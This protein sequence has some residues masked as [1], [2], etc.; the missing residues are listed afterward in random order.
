MGRMRTL[1]LGSLRILTI[2]ILA[3]SGS[4]FVSASAEAGISSVPDRTPGAIPE[5]HNGVPGPQRQMSGLLPL[6]QAQPHSQ[7]LERVGDPQPRDATGA[8]P[9]LSSNWSGLIDSGSGA[10]FTS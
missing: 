7:P 6:S 2:S 10:T 9:S 8:A 5:I 1:A 4:A 3:L